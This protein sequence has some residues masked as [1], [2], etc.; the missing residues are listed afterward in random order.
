MASSAQI[1]CLN[2]VLY[3]HSLRIILRAY[4]N[5]WFFKDKTT[6]FS[7]FLLKCAECL[8]GLNVKPFREKP[9]TPFQRLFCTRKKVECVQ[10]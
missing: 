6:V 10:F 3:M 5:Y 7:V 8:T 2:L 4:K 1:F 9:W